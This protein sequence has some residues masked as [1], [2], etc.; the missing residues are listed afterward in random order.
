MW[1]HGVG[2]GVIPA[3]NDTAFCAVDGMQPGSCEFVN[4]LVAAEHAYL[5]PGRPFF[6]MLIG[7]FAPEHEGK[8]MP[9][10]EHEGL[11]ELH[12]GFAARPF[13]QGDARSENGMPAI[14]MVG[15]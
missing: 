5:Q 7:P 6:R 4:A 8:L 11:D 14:E 3:Q 13:V 1:G 12:F 2:E 9:G 15:P 10:V